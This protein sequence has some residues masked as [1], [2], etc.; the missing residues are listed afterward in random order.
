MSCGRIDEVLQEHHD[1]WTAL[2]G[3]IGAGIGRPDG[4]GCLLIDGGAVEAGDMKNPKRAEG[5]PVLIQPS[6]EFRAR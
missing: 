2:A 5:Q 6:D 1:Q 3:V 4:E